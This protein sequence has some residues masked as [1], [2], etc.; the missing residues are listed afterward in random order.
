MLLIDEIINQGAPKHEKPSEKQQYHH[1][2]Q[3]TKLYREVF[4]LVNNSHSNLT[5]VNVFDLDP[6]KYLFAE[7]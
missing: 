5:F 3:K 7:Q 6:G 1:Q 4:D 2:L